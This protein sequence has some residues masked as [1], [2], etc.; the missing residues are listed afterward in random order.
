LNETKVF[1][2]VGLHKTGTTFLQ[3][4]V[5]KKISGINYQRKVDLTTHV[6]PGKINLF[7]DENLDGGSYRLF[8]DPFGRYHIATNLSKMFPDA[9]IIVF[10]RDEKSW[11]ISAWKQYVLSYFGYPFQEY[12][13]RID[14]TITDF[15]SYIGHLQK[16]FK[17]NVLLV[18][19][20]ELL[21]AP[22]DVVK[23]ICDFIGVPVPVFENKS[24]YKSLS[25]GQVGFIVF[26]DKIFRSKT[27]H[28]ILS[29]FIRFVR[30]DPTIQKFRSKKL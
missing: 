2:H 15:N 25:D 22:E 27:L 13:R 30:N 5:F 14:K 6:E 21:E 17:N 12:Y 10:T 24:V 7:S 19:Y 9:N 28:F 29:L 23:N 26:F 11:L 8:A 18:H 20:E 1:I 4:E 16:L 3:N